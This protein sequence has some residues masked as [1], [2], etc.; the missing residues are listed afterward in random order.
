MNATAPASSDRPAISVDSVSASIDGATLLDNVCLRVEGGEWISV[1]GPN[2]AGKSTLLRAIAGLLPVTGTIA[3]SGTNVANLNGRARARLVAWVPQTPTLPTGLR[4]L[5]YVLLGRTPHL[6]LL[7]TENAHDLEVAHAALAE[8]DLEHFAERAIDSL[9]GGELQRTVIAR[10]LAQEAPILLLDE[11][12][13]ALDLGHQ[14]DVLD[15]LDQLR[16]TG[17][18]TIVTTMHDLTLA[19]Q[20]G[21]RIVMLADGAIAAAGSATDVLTEDNLRRHY[22]AD[23]DVFERNGRLVVIPTDRR[24]PTPPPN[25]DQN[26]PS[27][28]D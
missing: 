6:G 12:T 27:T 28:P 3:L 13:S 18:R 9:S 17:D 21:D 23:V 1:I 10:A 2:G 22:G 14:Q 25:S 26:R 4:V 15:V 8:L 11:P 7:A 5:D 16:R 20:Y 24:S 19:G